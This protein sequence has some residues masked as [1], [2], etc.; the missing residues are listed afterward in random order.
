MRLATNALRVYIFS[1]LFYGRDNLPP[2]GSKFF[3]LSGQSPTAATSNFILFE[4]EKREK[5]L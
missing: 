5:I 3:Y 1:S 4:R 2:E